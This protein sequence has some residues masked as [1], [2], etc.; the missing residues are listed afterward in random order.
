MAELIAVAGSAPGVGKSTTC[1]Q[2][3]E[4]LS[5]LGLAVEHF[6]EE[7][8]LSRSEFADVAAE[9]TTTGVVGLRTLLQAT[10][11]YVDHLQA[12]G[13]DVAVAD[14]LVPFVPSLV[15][16][17]HDDHA[18]SKFLDELAE[19][20]L[21]VRPVIVYLDG[22]PRVALPRAAQR[23][24]DGWLDRYVGK[25]ADYG[26]QPAVRDLDTACAYLERE[27]ETTLRLIRSKPWQL[28]VIQRAHQLSPA[29][30]ASEAQHSLRSR[31][32]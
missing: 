11:S 8:I 1:G 3:A 18:I 10:S 25:L 16:W 14:S 32:G 23:E 27:R 20:L 29:D 19:L 5:G 21:P 17:G 7:D 15:A 28:V 12:S 31:F 13:V 9:F 2:L 6:Q 22:D 4:W 24:G 26:V 30:V